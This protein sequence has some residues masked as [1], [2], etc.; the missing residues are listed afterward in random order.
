MDF[1]KPSLLSVSESFSKFQE[2]GATS[3]PHTV[4]SIGALRGGRSLNSAVTTGSKIP[5]EQLRV[6]AHK[7]V[8]WLLPT[9]WKGSWV[10]WWSIRVAYF[11][12]INFMDVTVVASYIWLCCSCVCFLKIVTRR[13]P[14]AIIPFRHAGNIFPCDS[15]CPPSH[16]SRCQ[17]LK[18]THKSFEKPKCWL[19]PWH[20]SSRRFLHMKSSLF[21]S[22]MLPVRI[23]SFHKKPRFSW[24]FFSSFSLTLGGQKSHFRHLLMGS[25]PSFFLCDEGLRACFHFWLLE[26][27]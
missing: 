6:S 19:T 4:V 9:L 18:A 23:L 13:P 24:S 25:V 26:V 5:L 14:T 15:R 16:L 11:R 1:S 22:I 17:D 3:V 20:H 27:P 7:T 10:F 8:F 2:K 21:Y 12:M